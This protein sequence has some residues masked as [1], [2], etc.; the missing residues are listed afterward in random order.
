MILRAAT[1]PW[2]DR[3][4]SNGSCIQNEAG[5][6]ALSAIVVNELPSNVSVEFEIIVEV[7]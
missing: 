6:H 1:D 5:A 2:Q 4:S 3:K 7:E